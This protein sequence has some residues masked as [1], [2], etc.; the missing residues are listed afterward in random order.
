MES[1]ETTSSG[2]VD[3]REPGGPAGRRALPPRRARLASHRAAGVPS[4]GRGAHAPEPGPPARDA[5]CHRPPALRLLGRALAAGTLTGCDGG[6]VRPYNSADLMDTTSSHA[7]PSTAAQARTEQLCADWYA[8]HGEAI[9]NYLRFQLI[10]P[11]EA[12]DLTA[13]TFL[14]A[15][16]SADRFDP[17]GRR[18]RRGCSRSRGTCSSTTSAAC[19]RAAAWAS[20]SS[21]T[22]RW[23]R[24]RRRS[25]C[26]G[27][28]PWRACSR[29]WRN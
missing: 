25:G 11:D 12:E 9:Y 29:R 28:K 21:G 8:A 7:S 19:G 15:V 22:W 2:R 10:A 18:P 14:R 16:R 13:E 3:R 24:P 26:C 27:G 23:T 4:A 5:R 17:R 20:T 6:P 1:P